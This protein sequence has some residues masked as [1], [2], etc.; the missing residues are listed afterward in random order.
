MIVFEFFFIPVTGMKCSY[1]KIFI[2][3]TEISAVE[4]EI[5][6]TGLAFSYEHIEYFT[7]EIG[8]KRDLGNRAIP[9]NRDHMKRPLVLS[10]QTNDQSE[11]DNSFRTCEM[12]IYQYAK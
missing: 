2:P 7:K 9:V 4:T 5:S 8:V 3:V 12:S 10:L 1:G 6:V 11:C